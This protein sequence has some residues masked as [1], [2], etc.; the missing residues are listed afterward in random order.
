M[1]ID[2]DGTAVAATLLEKYELTYSLR[3]IRT[4]ILAA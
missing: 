4:T 2:P 3:G 1:R